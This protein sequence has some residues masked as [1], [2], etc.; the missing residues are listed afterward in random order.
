MNRDRCRDRGAVTIMMAL[1]LASSLSLLGVLEVYVNYK[2][3]EARLA[4]AM[5]Q[6]MEVL[7]ANYDRKLADR[8]GLMAFPKSVLTSRDFDE[9]LS[10]HARFHPEAQVSAENPL[11]EGSVLE[12]QILLFMRPRFPIAVGR[13]VFDRIRALDPKRRE[14]P[15]LPNPINPDRDLLGDVEFSARALPAQSPELSRAQDRSEPV[16]EL[17]W[18]HPLFPWINREIDINDGVNR[19]RDALEGNEVE[20]LLRY[21]E[22]ANIDEES[23]EAL[24]PDEKAKVDA[25]RRESISMNHLQEMISKHRR[26][27]SEL[28]AGHESVELANLLSR[29]EDLLQRFH[30]SEIPVYDA[31]CINEYAVSMFSCTS[32]P[33]N[34]QAPASK[35]NS[36]ITMR[37]HPF[38]TQSYSSPYEV[39]E[40]LTGL[41]GQSA[42]LLAQ[43]EVFLMRLLVQSIHLFTSPMGAN[44]LRLAAAGLTFLAWIFGMPIPYHAILNFLIFLRACKYSY[45]D[46]RALKRGETVP[47][48]PGHPL[49]VDYVD[50][51]RL[52]M[53]LVPRGTKLVRIGKQIARNCPGDFYTR[54]RI[55]AQWAVVGRRKSDAFEDYYRLSYQ[56]QDAS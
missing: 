46:L 38:A 19:L 10:M 25:L 39:E 36:H 28:F 16:Y 44:G 14:L 54:L 8:Y 11:A 55:E 52:F 32:R 23:Y 47:I 6:Q 3:F 17:L 33:H 27:G 42:A 34:G 48:Y 30:A 22:M 35:L 56:P 4:S 53:F 13:A 9:Q 37:S 5:T 7:L 20:E 21:R 2:L 24:S 49:Q 15:A 40:I 26:E 45:R 18:T 31:I 51:M 1:I 12:E 43:F 50:Y 41:S 29:A